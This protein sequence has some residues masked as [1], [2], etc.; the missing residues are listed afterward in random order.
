MFKF[1][2]S[3]GSL[4]PGSDYRDTEDITLLG[5]TSVFQNG[6]FL[7]IYFTEEEYAN[8]ASSLTGWAMGRSLESCFLEV[9]NNDQ[10]VV[11]TG[12]EPIY[13][14]DWEVTI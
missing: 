10:L 6:G 3:A 8:K 5:V 13:Y 4:D 12:E 14:S 7:R 11:N 1:N 2:L 9:E